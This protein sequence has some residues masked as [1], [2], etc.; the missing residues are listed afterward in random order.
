MLR[1]LKLQK[2]VK[3]YQK[4]FFDEKFGFTACCSVS[5]RNGFNIIGIHHRTDFFIAIP[6]S[7]WGA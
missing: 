5:D 4:Q 3:A 6:L 2:P 7:F 1:L